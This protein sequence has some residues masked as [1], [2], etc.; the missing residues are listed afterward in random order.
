[1]LVSSGTKVPR[2]N[3]CKS[4]LSLGKIAHQKWSDHPFSQRNRA[5]EKTVGVGVG[6]D[7]EFRGGSSGGQN[8][9]KKGGVQYR[10]GLHKIGGLAALCHL[11][12]D[13]KLTIYVRTMNFVNYYK[14]DDAYTVSKLHSI[15]SRYLYKILIF[16]L[17]IVD[18][19]DIVYL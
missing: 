1:M 16:S 14:I 4:K 7:R 10:R 9:R 8:L 12:K 11:C 5:T 2:V 6:G 19:S 17:Q 3:M 15:I 13:N 18:L